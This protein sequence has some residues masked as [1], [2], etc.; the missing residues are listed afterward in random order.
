MKIEFEVG[1]VSV[2]IEG[3]CPA[4]IVALLEQLGAGQEEPN[5][6]S[7]L[8]S[9]EGSRSAIVATIELMGYRIDKLVAKIEGE[10]R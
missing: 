9:L 3:Q 1:S 5:V 10:V 6:A 4:G 8:E 2:S 7:R